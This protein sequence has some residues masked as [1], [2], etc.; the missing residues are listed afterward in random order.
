MRAACTGIF[1]RAIVRAPPHRKPDMA[2]YQTPPDITRLPA[3]QALIEHRQAMRGFNLRDAFAAQPQ[4]FTDFS[5]TACGLF[6]DYSKNLITEETVTLLMRLAREA[7]LEDAIQAFL[8]GENVNASERR[9]AL[10][11]ALRRPIG[12]RVMVNG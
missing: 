11:T 8:D 9:P 2:Y 4:R 1:H 6:L 10:H 12:E 3:W 7:G 5:L